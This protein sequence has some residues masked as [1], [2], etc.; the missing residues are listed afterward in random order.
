M[1]E[2]MHPA[3]AV[4]PLQTVRE[5][6]HPKSVA[7]VGASGDEQKWGGRLLRYMLRHR[8]DGPL[9]PINARA[10]ELMGLPAYASLRD[11]P[12]PVDLAILLVPR[13]HV[14][15]AVED[16]VAK[17][18]GCALCITAGF[19]ETGEKGRADEAELVA[20]ARALVHDP[21]LVLADEPTGT[22]D[23]ETG[24]KVLDLFS[25]LLRERGKTLLIVTHSKEVTRFAE[26][27]LTLE[28]GQLTAHAPEAVW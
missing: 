2:P 11:C 14:R 3:S 17:G 23:A 9:Y 12:G 28:D 24:R 7:I 27:V 13:E 21:M 15:A 22:L 6:L 1:T 5:I 18:V 20:I 8:H 16:C 19:A 26:R 25:R 4:T 10:K